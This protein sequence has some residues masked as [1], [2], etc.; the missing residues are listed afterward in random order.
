[1]LKKAFKWLLGLFI[2]CT[3][4]FAGL[5]FVPKSNEQIYRMRVEKGQGI[6][7]VS[8]KLADEN[9]VYNRHVMLVAA[10][11]TGVHNQLHSGTYRLPKQ[12]STWQILQRLRDG[13]PDTITIRITEGMRFSQMRS[14]INNTADL[15]HDTQGW[16]DEKLLKEIDPSPLSNNPEGL[17]FPDSYEIDAESSDLQIYRLAYR[18]MQRHLQAAWDERQSG[19][20]YKNP[21]DLLIMASLIEKETGHEA[22]RRHVSAVF[23]NRL[24]IGMRLQTD[25]AVIYG[26]G[27]RYNGRIRKADL[28]RDTPYNTYT[29][30]GLTPTPI[31]LPGKAALEAAAHPSPEK[32]LY[33]VSR[34]DGTGL[35]QFSHNLDEHNAAVR[36]YIL[37]K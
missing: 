23:V 26:M 10:Y 12:I 32:Y 17:F 13:R 9:I 28:Q 6:S 29:R 35:S 3:L 16:S 27:S 8:R 37:K 2:L 21:Y 4:V 33:F 20:P 34:M 11:L 30:A 18:T 14:I 22:D 19:L 1:M 31:A 25:P 36:K 5:L 24:N 7:A 15:K